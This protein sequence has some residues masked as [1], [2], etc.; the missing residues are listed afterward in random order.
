MR[1]IKRSSSKNSENI[2]KSK[3]FS[4]FFRI[5]ESAKVE[6]LME[7]MQ[8]EYKAMKDQHGIDALLKDSSESETDEYIGKFIV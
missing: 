8:K 1:S 6:R 5:G 4:S 3:F 2:G 7:H